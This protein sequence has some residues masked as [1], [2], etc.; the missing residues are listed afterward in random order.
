M[1][2]VLLPP[3]ENPIAVKYI[4][5]YRS[6]GTRQGV[7]DATSQ[8]MCCGKW[9]ELRISYVIL[10]RVPAHEHKSISRNLFTFG[11]MLIGIFLFNW[12]CGIHRNSLWRRF[13][14]ILY[15]YCLYSIYTIY[16]FVMQQEYKRI[17]TVFG[18]VHTVRTVV[19]LL[20]KQTVPISDLW[21]LMSSKHLELS[22]IL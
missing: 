14:D 18:T 5:S 22:S 4:I 20:H 16:L 12:G 17:T 7:H 9:S 11:P 13:W 21:H 3:G 15:M 1:C 8:R 19:V 10:K 2:T 6:A